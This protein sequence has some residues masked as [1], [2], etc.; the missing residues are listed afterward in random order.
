MLEREQQLVK[1]EQD[2]KREEKDRKKEKKL[3]KEKERQKLKAL[4]FADE[5]LEE[6]GGNIRCFGE[7]KILNGSIAKSESI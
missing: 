5:E 7:S 4:S 1:K 6:E 3:K 2:K